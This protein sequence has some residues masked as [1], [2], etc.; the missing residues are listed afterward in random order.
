MHVGTH[1]G[2]KETGLTLLE[3]LLR[4]EGRIRGRLATIRV[5]PLQAALTE[6]QWPMWGIHLQGYC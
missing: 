3:L 2:R 6:H 1:H 5:T 4:L